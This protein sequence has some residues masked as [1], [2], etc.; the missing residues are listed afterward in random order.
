MNIKP[1]NSNKPKKEYKPEYAQLMVNFFKEGFKNHTK[2][3]FIK[4]NKHLGINCNLNHWWRGKYPAFMAAYLEVREMAKP[5]TATEYRRADQKI[6][7]KDIKDQKKK[8]RLKKVRFQLTNEQL[9]YDPATSDREESQEKAKYREQI[10]HYLSDPANELLSLARV[11]EKALDVSTPSD[12][13]KYFNA[14]EFS[15]MFKQA[16]EN[17]RSLY[18]PEIAKID[19]AQLKLAASGGPGSTAA[20]KLMYQKMEGWMEKIDGGGQSSIVIIQPMQIE[21]KESQ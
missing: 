11:A 10:M 5:K 13:Y 7:V 20:A 18:A 6:R 15:H 3:T 9:G 21:K 12:I 16:L 4:F 8:K 19:K 1:N 2:P 14:V 17:R